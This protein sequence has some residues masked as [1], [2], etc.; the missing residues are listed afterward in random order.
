LKKKTN[1]DENYV[2]DLCDMVLGMNSSRQHRFEFLLGDRNK[3][4][5]AA[6]LPVDGYYQEKNLVIEYHER[7]HTE[8]AVFFDKP[9]KITVSGVTRGEQRK[10]YDERRR[11]VLLERKIALIE[12]SYHDFDHNK[13]KRIIR[14]CYLDKEIVTKKLN[15]FV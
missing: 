7:Q 14:S 11:I 15:N 1:S 13:Q 10:I 6:K 9:N 4:G 5:I 8:T 3:R 12:F 2:L